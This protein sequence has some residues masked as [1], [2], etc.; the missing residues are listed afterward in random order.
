MGVSDT[1]SL[2]NEGAIK[3]AK[4]TLNGE[5]LS[6]QGGAS[7]T[8]AGVNAGGQRVS[9]GAAG[10]IAPG[11]MDAINGG[12]M[13]DYQRQQDDRWNRLTPVSVSWTSG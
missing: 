4:A 6:I 10:A 9:G 1:I 2:S 11:S 12:Q 3:V 5:G 13:W 7:V 8:T